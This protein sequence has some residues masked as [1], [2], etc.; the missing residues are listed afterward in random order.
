[1]P[2]PDGKQLLA[3]S[4]LGAIASYNPLTGERKWTFKKEI[5]LAQL[6]FSRRGDRLIARYGNL[7]RLLDPTDGKLLQ[8]YAGN[9]GG[10]VSADLSPDGKHLLTA[11]QDGSS[12]L[13]DAGSGKE[14]ANLLSFRDGTWAVVDPMGRYDA[15]NGG[16]I[17]GLH[18]VANNEPISLKQLKKHYY[19][20]GLLAKQMGIN[21]QPL[22]PV[23]ALKSVRLAPD[24]AANPPTKDGKLKVNLTN[25]AGGLGRVQV[26][27]NGKELNADA[28]GPAVKQNP[29]TK[30]AT[31]EIDLKNAHYLAGEKN[32][33]RIVPWNKEDGLSGRGLVLDWDAPGE[34]DKRPPD[35]YAVVV[36]VSDYAEP[37]LTLRYAAKDAQDFAKALT[38]AGERL[39]T[40]AGGKVH[41]TLLC[42]IDGKSQQPTRANIVKAL[43]AI[44]KQAKPSDVLVVYLAGHGVAL[45]GKDEL[46][47]CYLTQEANS[48]SR[49]DL[50]DKEWRERNCLTSTELTES[51]KRIAANKQ[52]MVLDT[53][54]AG[55]AVGDLMKNREID[56][57]AVRA[58][59]RLQERAGFHVLMGC[60]ADKV[61]YEATRFGQ[62]LLTYS[63]LEG[64]KGA[65]LK[66]NEFVDVSILF[67]HA[68]NRVPQLAHNI[69][70]IQKPIIMAPRGTSFDV[71]RL[72]TKDK[73]LIPLATDKPLLLRPRMT[74]P[75]AD[76][77]DDLGLEPLLSKRLLVASSY[78]SR[79]KGEA[80]TLAY[81]DA[82]ELPGAIR[83]V[84][85]YK[86]AGDR[87]IVHIALRR[88]KT[89]LTA[90]E[91][92]GRRDNLPELTN[93]ITDAITEALKKIP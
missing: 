69:G 36:G 63:L 11:H 57:E 44:A 53:C 5:S 45:E 84:G 26:F 38:L 8:T 18:W 27:V 25:R 15:S 80:P 68:A 88:E 13:W 28:R 85:T 48:T 74:N 1:L 24:A 73:A 61:S 22:R 75:G 79:G 82:A 60:A 55:A 83:P 20:P 93:R 31:L 67:Q 91:V 41:V 65:A 50:A 49:A 23:E 81:I 37:K 71:G 17:E 54:A 7:A 78:D 47:Y 33:I 16:D 6:S 34:K 59:D 56:A 58:L 72:L 89:T 76:N 39:L 62:G 14:L 19:E 64:M 42:Q 70:G 10:I 92:E 46:L 4:R 77:D 51:F 3:V 32:V 87:V 90:V 2:S 29:D 30:E 35:L 86:V 12:R 43:D 21:K 9:F 66:E 52:V 40:E